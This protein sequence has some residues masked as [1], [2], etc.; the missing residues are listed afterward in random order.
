M[1]QFSLLHRGVKTH[2]NHNSD[3]SIKHVVGKYLSLV[4]HFPDGSKIITIVLQFVRSSEFQ[5][6]SFFVIF[7]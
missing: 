7:A 5:T 1:W 2:N 6:S 4:V 3:A